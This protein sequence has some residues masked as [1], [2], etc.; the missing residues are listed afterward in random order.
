[1]IGAILL[2]L[3]TGCTTPSLFKPSRADV[4]EQIVPSAVQ[5]VLER[6]GQRVRSG[7]GVAI[8]APPSARG[9][10][11][12]VLTS[13][14]TL[15]RRSETDRVLVLFDRHRGAGV[16]AAATVVAHRDTDPTDLALLRAHPDACFPAQF[17]HRPALGDPIWVV[18][19]PWGRN[20]TL[21]GGIVSQVNRDPPGDRTTAPRFIVDA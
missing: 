18:A 9:T 1:M 6:D 11:C 2:G 21:V 19:Y 10:E 4:I 3:S 16:K 14:H 20:L 15:A 17:G 12:F 7:S 13:G 5:I 8:A